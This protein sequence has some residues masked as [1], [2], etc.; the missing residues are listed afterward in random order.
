MTVLL[1]TWGIWSTNDDFIHFIPADCLKP[2]ACTCYM[3]IFFLKFCHAFWITVSHCYLNQSRYSPR[4]S[5]TSTSTMY[6]L[7]TDKNPYLCNTR[8][9]LGE[10]GVFQS[11][12]DGMSTKRKLLVSR[13]CCPGTCKYRNWFYVNLYILLYLS[14]VYWF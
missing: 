8:M 1:D 4:V 7:L 5:N 2:I 14:L 12:E 3:S 6:L 10:N 11:K 13:K 9:E